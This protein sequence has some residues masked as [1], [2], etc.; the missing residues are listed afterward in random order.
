MRQLGC[1]LSLIA[2][3]GS[4]SRGAYLQKKKKQEMR[5]LVEFQPRIRNRHLRKVAGAG[6]RN[7]SFS[8]DAKLRALKVQCWL[9]DTYNKEYEY[10]PRL[11]CLIGRG[12]VLHWLQYN[13]SRCSYFERGDFLTSGYRRLF[14]HPIVDVQHELQRRPLFVFCHAVNSK[15]AG[16]S[17][18][19]GYMK[20]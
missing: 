7:N 17:N 3:A 9:Q 14:S 5:T 1:C 13:V 4:G 16:V 10:W 15:N 8:L 6:T 20:I 11:C 19:L 12:C 18:I 2:H